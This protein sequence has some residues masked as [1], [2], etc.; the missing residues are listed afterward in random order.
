MGK[1]IRSLDTP[2]NITSFSVDHSRIAVACGLKDIKVYSRLTFESETLVGH[3]K[4]VRAVKLEGGRLL[5]G[6]YDSTV[7]LWALAGR[8]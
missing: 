1:T 8:I 6:G 3:G 2:G 7:R 5:S 4:V